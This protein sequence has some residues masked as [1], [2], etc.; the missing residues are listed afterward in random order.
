MDFNTA[1][2]AARQ[3]P[4]A[5][6]SHHYVEEKLRCALERLNLLRYRISEA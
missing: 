2:S 5:L 4:D 6:A 1:L 3:H